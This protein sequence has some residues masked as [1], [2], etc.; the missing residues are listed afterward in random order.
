MFEQNDRMLTFI[1]SGGDTKDLR[2]H[3]NPVFKTEGANLSGKTRTI[4]GFDDEKL[5]PP[6]GGL[7]SYRKP[8]NDAVSIHKVPPAR[9]C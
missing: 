3:G 5:S 6:S 7:F 8:E 4:R 2:S 1:Q 9:A